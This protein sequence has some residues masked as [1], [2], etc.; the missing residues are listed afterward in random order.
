MSPTQIAFMKGKKKFEEEFNI[1][2]LI[3]TIQKMKSAI[4][5]LMEQTHSN[6][7]PLINIQDI[8]ENYFKMCE[9][10]IDDKEEQLMIDDKSEIMKFFDR[11]YQ[12]IEMI[13]NKIKKDKRHSIND[14][15]L[16]HYISQQAE[17]DREKLKNR[18]MIKDRDLYVGKKEEE[19]GF[20]KKSKT[21][22]KEEFEKVPNEDP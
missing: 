15:N 22:T 9:I 6:G 20:W 8:K 12:D 19:E 16:F 4:S 21:L 13:I 10:I 18:L 1:F 2:N 7:S 14:Q 5:L 3:K 11:D 17:G